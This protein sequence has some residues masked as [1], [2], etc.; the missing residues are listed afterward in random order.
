VDRAR[1]ITCDAEA[2]DGAVGSSKMV[3][4]RAMA[5]TARIA[6]DAT[7]KKKNTVG[8]GRGVLEIKKVLQFEAIRTRRGTM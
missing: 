3:I 2:V 7:Y 4:A 6:T 5:G 1:L 8:Y